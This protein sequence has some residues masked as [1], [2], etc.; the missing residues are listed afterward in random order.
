MTKGTDMAEHRGP[1][2]GYAEVNGARLYYEEAGAGKS[3]VLLHAGIGNCHFWDDQWEPFA[4]EYHVV[5]YDLRGFGKSIR[6]RGPF[7]MRDDLYR[8]IRFL[9][10]EHAHLVGASIGG[11]I[12]I[13][14]T[15]EHP[16]MVDAL[17]AVVP[18]LSGGPQPSEEVMRVSQEIEAAQRA[19]DLD[20]AD[21]LMVRVWV[22][23]PHRR[24]EDIDAAVRERVLQMLR[25]NRAAA[26]AEGTPV[27]LDPP[28]RG[29]L[30]E[31]HTPTLVIVGEIDVPVILETS[32][33]IAR[34]VAGARK[35]VMHGVAH[36]PNM[37]RP[38]EFN[39]NVLNFLRSQ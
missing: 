34:D 4:Q 2:S 11:G 17:I 38:E 15:L 36:A 14:F 31:I 8:L 13:D 25:D 20:H 19:G 37:E 30:G 23:G 39:R 10:I 33:I 29:R 22:D 18:G 28:A 26:F 32:D 27:R 16:E 21:E 7:N 5:R 1:T 24:P 9:D 3:L 12:A 6:P 35:V